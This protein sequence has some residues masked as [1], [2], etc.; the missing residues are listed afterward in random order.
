MVPDPHT[1]TQTHY[2]PTNKQDRLQYTAPQLARSVINT[3][4]LHLIV[5]LIKYTDHNNQAWAQ[6]SFVEAE[7]RQGS[8]VLN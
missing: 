8:N 1:Q 5:L 6:G 4:N 2:T 3:S 7:A